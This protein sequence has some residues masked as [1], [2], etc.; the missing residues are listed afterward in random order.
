ML[1]RSSRLAL[2]SPLP[3]ARRARHTLVCATAPPTRLAGVRHIS[4]IARKGEP[5]LH[6]MGYWSGDGESQAR[7]RADA[8]AYEIAA[9]NAAED[10]YT[11]RPS[12][13][14]YANRER[15]LA[16][17]MAAADADGP[18]FTHL[19]E[20]IPEPEDRRVP[21][22]CGVV[23]NVLRREGALTTAQLWEKVSERYPGIIGT[24][25]F[26]KQKI[27]K[28]ALVN[29]LIKVR[30]PT[31]ATAAIGPAPPRGARSAALRS[32]RRAA[33]ALPRRARS[34]PTDA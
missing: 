29:R 22:P 12:Y 4:G 26:M 21:G 1:L 10:G 9:A 19:S 11:P 16:G 17:L 3:L 24:K 34:S 6:G 18:E 14:R 13:S 23:L 33:L 30:D 28:K 2:P 20:L 32:L 7:A 5:A 8:E 31:P 15:L 25:A 27:L